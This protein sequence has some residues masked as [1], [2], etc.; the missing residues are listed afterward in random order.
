[1]TQPDELISPRIA[2]LRR[3]LA[4]GD[5]D[6]LP[7]FWRS[8]AERGTPL[9]EPVPDDTRYALVTF[10]W[11]GGEDTRNV[12][13]VGG[14]ADRDVAEDFAHHQMARL[15]GTD[16]WFRTYR[17]RVEAHFVYRLSPNDSLISAADVT[18]WH[19]Q[20]ATFQADPLNRQ[21]YQ[22]ED[23]ESCSVACLP[24]AAPQPWSE[25]EPVTLARPVEEHEWHSTA[26]GTTRSVWVYPPPPTYSPGRLL[27]LFDGPSYVHGS[28]LPAL[29]DRLLAD[30]DASWPPTLCVNVG[31]AR[32]SQSSRDVELG[33]NPRFTD[34]LVDELLP[35]LQRRYGPV[36][37]ARDTVV[38][39][40][41][42][43]GLAA[44]YAALR[45]PDVFGNVL[46]QF[47]FFSWAPPHDGADSEDADY[48]WLAHQYLD[49]PTLPV[50]FALNVGVFD[51]VEFPN[52]KQRPSLLLAN[53][54][55]RDI[56]RAKGYPVAY[57]EFH[58][59]HDEL[60]KQTT[61]PSMLLALG[62]FHESTVGR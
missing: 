6:A 44:A 48:E 34:A 24:G 7:A 54:H 1:M 13:V 23:G 46:S 3:A 33:C 27:V 55:F 21:P 60:S 4:G 30:A 5:R 14:V 17:T 9:V 8:V 37:Q 16:V 36:P 43:G 10:L 47:G 56:L 62:G 12:V 45:H 38:G 19:A 15:P 39:G 58:G 49:G 20:E 32:D 29:L 50:R 51:P 31:Q 28:P 41:S 22:S 35:W 53:R 57:A 26:L 40:S 2:A 25:A 59:G 11:R 42:L 18:D 61:L 52:H